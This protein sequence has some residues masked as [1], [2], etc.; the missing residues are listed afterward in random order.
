MHRITVYDYFSSAHQLRG[1]K[2]KCEELHGHNWKVE[3]QIESEDLDNLGMLMDFKD[4]KKLLKEM[5]DELDHK[6][7]NDL[8]PF[9]KVNPS[10]ENVAKYIYET[11]SQRL[12]EGI[13]LVQTSVWESEN[14]KTTYYIKQHD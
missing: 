10:S 3:I 8:E 7:L 12:P 14:S 1:Y 9:K 11:L 5:V 2:G 6:M 13:D 4:V